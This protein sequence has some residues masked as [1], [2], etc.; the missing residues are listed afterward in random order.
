MIGH[1]P[2]DHEYLSQAVRGT[3]GVYGWR[4]STR[5]VK[6]GWWCSTGRG[7]SFPFDLPLALVNGELPAASDPLPHHTLHVAHGS[8]G[9][10]GGEY[11]SS[12]WQ[13][14]CEWAWPEARGGLGWPRWVPPALALLLEWIAEGAAE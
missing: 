4:R 14:G 11:P 12:P 2:P 3:Q 9:A 8:C 1:A 5:L 13:I 7:G 6:P 10:G